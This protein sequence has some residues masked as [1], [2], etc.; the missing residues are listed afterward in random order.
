MGIDVVVQSLE[1]ALERFSPGVAEFL[2]VMPYAF[3]GRVAKAESDAAKHALAQARQRSD[4]VDRSLHESRFVA[5]LVRH[6]I[7]VAA[8]PAA[9][10]EAEEY[11]GRVDIPGVRAIEG[12]ASL[13]LSN[14]VPESLE[15]LAGMLDSS[16]TYDLGPFSVITASTYGTLILPVPFAESVHVEAC[17]LSSCPALRASIR[18]LLAG[19]PFVRSVGVETFVARID[20]AAAS[21]PEPLNQAFYDLGLLER[22]A[23]LAMARGHVGFVDG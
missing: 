21:A 9:S 22:A 5:S 23:M 16:R 19:I 6:G 17:S 7:D 12:L 18:S 3:R 14:A 2:A 11:V 1:S 10:E 4:A 20:A 8:W 13:V 15:A